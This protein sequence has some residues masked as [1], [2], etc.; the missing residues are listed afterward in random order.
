MSEQA[1]IVTELKRE[2]RARGLTYR[3]VAAA[4]KLSEASVKRLFSTGRF[5]L[6]RLARI[7]TFLD[8]TLAELTQG[9]AAS[10]PRLR[11]LTLAQETELVSD[12]KL[13]LVAVLALN[14]WRLNDMV[15]A[16]R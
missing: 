14:H 10:E 7:A 9:A 3:H 15:T 4:L 5:T 8:L 1:R 16:Y 12:H 2:L 6:D 11:Q 13:L